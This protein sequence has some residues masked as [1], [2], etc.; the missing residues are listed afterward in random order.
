MSRFLFL[1]CWRL[2]S[3][4]WL[5]LRP[6]CAGRRRAGPP[7]YHPAAAGSHHGPHTRGSP[8]LLSEVRPQLQLA[9]ESAPPRHHG[10]RADQTVQV[11]PLPLQEHS[12]GQPHDARPTET[13]GPS[14]SPGGFHRL[15]TWHLT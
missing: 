14:Y 13:Q 9:T 2:L 5:G 10:V 15:A 11:P 6:R 3:R 1:N 4:R 8:L 7:G 12:Q